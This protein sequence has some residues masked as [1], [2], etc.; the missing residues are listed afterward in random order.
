MLIGYFQQR[1]TGLFPAAEGG[2]LFENIFSRETECAQGLAD[3][4]L[5]ENIA[6]PAASVYMLPYFIEYGQAVMEL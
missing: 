2:N 3:I 1:Q 5:T 4:C 6:S